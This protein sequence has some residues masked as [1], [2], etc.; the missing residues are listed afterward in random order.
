MFVNFTLGKLRDAVPMLEM[1]EVC[2]MSAGV[3]LSLFPARTPRWH[4]GLQT[5]YWCLLTT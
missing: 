3:A 2:P 1:A 5:D 4:R